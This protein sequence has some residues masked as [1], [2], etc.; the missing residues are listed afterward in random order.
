MSRSRYPAGASCGPRRNASFLRRLGLFPA[1]LAPLLLTLAA[2]LPARPA[3]AE[4]PSPGAPAA[5]GTE[6]DRLVAEALARSPDLA[7]ARATA[8]A[9]ASRVSPASALPDPMLSVGYENDGTGI[10][11]GEEPMTRLTFMAQQAIP[12]PGKLRLAG[13]IAAKDADRSRTAPERVALDLAASVKRAYADLVEARED[14][15]LVEDQVETWKA[16]EEVTRARYTAG[17][18][19]QQDVIRAQ[20]ERTRL[21][22][23]RARDAAAEE[24]ALARLRALLYLPLDAPLPTTLRLA[25]GSLPEL[26]A[27]DE[28][29]ARALDVTPELK[30]AALAKERAGLSEDLARRQLKPDLVVSAG[31]MNRGSLPLMW[32]AGIGVSVPL[33]AGKKQRPLVASARSEA[34]AAA[35]RE[36]S[37]RRTI[38]GLTQQR[39]VRLRQLAEEAKLD[40]EG[41]LVQDRLSV[42]SALA[43]YRTGAVPFVTVLEALSTDFTDR[44]AAVGRLADLI[45]A[46]ADLEEYSLTGSPSSAMVSP[47]P[48]SGASAGSKM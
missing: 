9:A 2:A 30:E 23:Q 17:M 42:E 20:G 14:Q 13:E 45:R 43:S 1:V 35:A 24:T 18:G 41:V 32:S 40:A 7:A 22:Q 27:A 36:E 46:R 33:W 47:A 44:R 34:A 4:E 3:H 16:I 29:L 28:A 6:L 11:L 21:L 8:E 15:R 12:F 19:S 39:L 26:P 25:P 48:P 31:Y 5:P 38:E 37:L 10:S